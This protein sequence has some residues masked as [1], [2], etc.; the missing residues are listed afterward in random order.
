MKFQFTQTA[1]KAWG[2]LIRPGVPTWTV[3]SSYLS[4]LAGKEES[5][6]HTDCFLS[7]PSQ[8]SRQGSTEAGPGVGEAEAAGP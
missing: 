4:L 1:V 8:L 6:S 7:P 2:L 5:G 3:Y